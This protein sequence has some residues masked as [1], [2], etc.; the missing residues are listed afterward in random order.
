MR[1]IV[2]QSKMSLLDDL[3]PPTKYVFYDVI[4]KDIL[5]KPYK[6]IL[7]QVEYKDHWGEQ[8]VQVQI[9][10]GGDSVE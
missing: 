5:W 7:E 4:D 2:R 6:Y 10:Q 3:H 8:T 9:A 1:A